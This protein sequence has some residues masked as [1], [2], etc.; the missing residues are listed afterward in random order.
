MIAYLQGT[1]KAKQGKTL[2]ID[3]HQVGYGVL[4]P[5]STA[6]HLSIGGPVELYIHTH[7]REDA[8][9]LYGLPSTEALELFK[10]LITISGVGPKM[11]LAVFDVGELVTI[12]RAIA[13][14]D[15]G[16]L[17]KVSGVGK[18]TAELIIIKLRDKSDWGAIDSGSS[19]ALD[20][21][22]ALGYPLADAREVLAQIPTE[23]A[24]T[25]GR[26]R[27]ALQKLSHRV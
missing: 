2:I 9:E 21:L 27:A 6:Y 24:D 25:E 17:T 18:K 4:V 26:I 20:A 12:K 8:L 23:I 7:V 15:A 5:T 11:A 3:V 13:A 10:Q 19:E 16:F 14:G 1:L 22:V